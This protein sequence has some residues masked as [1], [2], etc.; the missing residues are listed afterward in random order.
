MRR[1]LASFRH[2]SGMRRLRVSTRRYLPPPEHALVGREQPV[3]RY[4]P[5][6][7]VHDVP[8]GARIEELADGRTTVTD[9]ADGSVQILPICQRPKG[10]ANSLH[11]K[12][13]FGSCR[14]GAIVSLSDRSEG[15][16]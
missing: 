5:S 4:L 6:Q 9:P 11:L 3:V 12:I 8:H 13:R 10:C 16:R 7:C 2:L 14:D 1:G 15:E